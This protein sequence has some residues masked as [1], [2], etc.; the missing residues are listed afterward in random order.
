MA[1]ERALIVGAGPAGLT[2][3]IQLARYGLQAR[4]FE[5]GM[6]GGLLRNANLVENYPGF[7]NGIP[8]LQL[9]EIFRAQA[10][11]WG[12][13]VTPAEVISLDWQ[14]ERFVAVTSAGA[15]RA[16]F[17]L[18]ASGTRPLTFR[19]FPIPDECRHLVHYEVYPL[20]GISAKRVV[21]VG[22]GD[23]A[24]DYGL[25][26]AK[27]NEVVILNRGS[28]T[29]CLDLLRERAARQPR[30]AYREHTQVKGL[31]PSPDGGLMVE[32]EG[33][34]GPVT[35]EADFLLG[36]LGREPRLD[37]LAPGLQE[38]KD[39]LLVRGRLHLIGDVVNGRY[40][41]TAIAAGDGLRA[42]MRIHEVIQGVNV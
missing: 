20:L 13:Q 36:A 2:A 41:Q 37:F 25:N 31:Q 40:R 26:L 21:I 3:A 10:E 18:V 9:T 24:F 23:A 38:Q 17:A 30:I 11:R 35:F 5:A 7:P 14:D 6:V 4:V 22:A 1:D 8:G 42:A 15:Y 16:P 29:R 28:E 32:C 33:P 19:D 27:A 12:V 39:A 34:A